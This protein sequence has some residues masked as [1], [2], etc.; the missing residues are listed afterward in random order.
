MALHYAKDSI[1]DVLD[2]LFLNSY[3]MEIIERIFS[4]HCKWLDAETIFSCHGT[5]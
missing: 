1:R 3:L 2:R 4:F 5:I